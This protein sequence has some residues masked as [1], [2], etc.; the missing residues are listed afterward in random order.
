MLDPSEWS[1]Y[2]DDLNRRIEHGEQ[3]EASVEVTGE[4]VDGTEVELLPLDGI[5]FERH[6]DQ[7]A[8]GVGGRGR[9]YPA[10]LWHFVDGPR[11]VWVREQDGAPAS[12]GI[13][14]E[15]GTYTFVRLRA[16][17]SAT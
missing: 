2:F 15:D 8:I 6:D 4:D 11:R 7:I 12:L 1:R 3:F 16:A 10:V 5:T 17:A 9:R 14:S 13:E